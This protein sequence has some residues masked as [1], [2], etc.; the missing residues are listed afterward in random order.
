MD[1]DGP[2][3]TAMDRDGSGWIP[4][5]P[6][7]PLVRRERPLVAGLALLLLPVPGTAAARAAGEELQ[8]ATTWSRAIFW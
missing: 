2:G 5:P 4:V 8:S 1:R 7:A 3:W 6:I